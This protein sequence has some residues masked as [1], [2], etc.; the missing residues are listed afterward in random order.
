MSEQGELSFHTLS[1]LNRL[2]HGG[3]LLDPG[4]I[5]HEVLHGSLVDQQVRAPAPHHAKVSKSRIWPGVPGVCN[6]EACL[7]GERNTERVGTVDGL[8]G[9]NT[10]QAQCLQKVDHPVRVQELHLPPLLLPVVVHHQ[11]LALHQFGVAENWLKPREA[12]RNGKK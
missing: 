8:A 4:I 11:V 7:R 10:F 12:M 3:M 9:G 5:D 1:L 2:S 6:L